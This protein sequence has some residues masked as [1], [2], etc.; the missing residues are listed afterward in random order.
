MRLIS[1]LLIT[2]L[3]FSTLAVT[4]EENLLSYSQNG[5]EEDLIDLLSNQH[6]SNINYY[7]SDGNT[8]LHLAAMYSHPNII[9]ILTDAEPYNA[10]LGFN[11]QN[12]EGST[13]LYLS[14]I[15]NCSECVNVV[16]NSKYP[17]NLELGPRSTDNNEI[18]TPLAVSVV[19]GKDDIATS[20]INKGADLNSKIYWNISKVTVTI[21]SELATANLPNALNAAIKKSS[22][23]N[24]RARNNETPL[25]LATQHGK[26]E[27]VKML[28]DAKALLNLRDINGNTALHLA[29]NYIFKARETGDGEIRRIGLAMYDYLVQAGAKVDLTNNAGELPSRGRGIFAC[30]INCEN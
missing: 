21:L 29:S 17:I 7:N 26:L 25:M 20:L 24:I 18:M 3:S 22:N 11:I 19:R 28:V 9:K 23:L 10:Q 2:I 27:N 30:R 12:K 8:A 15:S 1:L 16:L 5:Y 14:V 4:N 13:P 6:V